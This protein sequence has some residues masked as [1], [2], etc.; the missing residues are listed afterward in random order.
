MIQGGDPAG[1]GKGD[2]IK[3]INIIRIGNK[4]TAFKADQDSFDVLLAK[5]RQKRQ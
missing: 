5:L 1:N 2:T 4:A 3:N